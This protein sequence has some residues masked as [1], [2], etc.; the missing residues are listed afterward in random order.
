MKKFSPE[1]IHQLKLLLELKQDLSDSTVTVGHRQAGSA[2]ERFHFRNQGTRAFVSTGCSKTVCKYLHSE[3]KLF[4]KLGNYVHLRKE[5]ADDRENRQKS[6]AVRPK[7][8]SR[9]YKQKRR[10]EGPE[11]HHVKKKRVETLHQLK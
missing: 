5:T 10:S 4:K 3:G 11:E 7:P 1:S 9:H 6:I 2:S 8:G